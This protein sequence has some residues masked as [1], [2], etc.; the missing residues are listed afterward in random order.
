VNIE[1]T[2]PDE[3]AGRVVESAL[4]EDLGSGGDVT[5]KATIPA[6]RRARA[7][8][9]AREDLVPAGL[10][11]VPIVLAR[12][13]A[14]LGAD[15]PA[16]ERDVRD[17]AAV[18][19]GASLALV[20]GNA[21]VILAGERVLL[22][23]L[24][25]LSGIASLTAQAVREVAGTGARIADTR[26]TTPLLRALEKYAVRVGGGE[27]HR[28][29]LD[30]LV[31]VKDNH[32]LIAGGLRPAIDAL[33][34]A[35]ID[36]ADAEIEVDSWEEFLVALEAGAGWILLDNM[37]PDQVRRCA[38]HAAGRVRLEVSGGL[39]PGGLRPY[40]ECGVD[41]LSLGCLTHGA[42]AVDVALDV[43]E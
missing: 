4:A 41:R 32:K 6:A 37:S 43:V 11:L 33:R 9:V 39:R 23:L 15:P 27:N 20:E 13:A 10:P 12:T 28:E 17:G 21:R 42:R 2:F 30:E 7:R 25:R 5:S 38:G 8:L 24:A 26:K 18:R 34:A 40:A 19:A 1:D 36:P 14:R 22:N 3:A 29:R 31:M 16:V 35:G